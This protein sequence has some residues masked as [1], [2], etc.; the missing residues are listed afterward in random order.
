MAFVQKAEKKPDLDNMMNEVQEKIEEKD[1]E[2]AILWDNVISLN[3]N[4]TQMVELP[5]LNPF[6]YVLFTQ[7]KNKALAIARKCLIL[8]CGPARAWTYDLQIMSL[9]K[10]YSMRLCCL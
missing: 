6:V 2:F 10:W 7:R 8:R 4:D 1:S 3:F 9:A 5:K